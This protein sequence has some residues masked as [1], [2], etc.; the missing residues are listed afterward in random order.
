MLLREA[1]T[2]I[3]YFFKGFL[4]TFI[5]CSSISIFRVILTVLS[6]QKN[7]VFCSLFV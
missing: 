5:S 6:F 2:I 3:L 1:N 4:Y 7:S